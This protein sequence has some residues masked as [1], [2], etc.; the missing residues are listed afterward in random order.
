M[1]ATVLAS[2]SR[3]SS[4]S[5]SKALAAAVS[6]GQRRALARAVTLVESS[7]PDHQEAAG[8]LLQQLMPLTGKAFRIGISGAPGVGKSSFIEALGLHLIAAGYKI[9]VLS[10]DPSSAISGGSILGDK[11][12]M[13]QLSRQASAFIRPSPAGRTLGGIA[14]H[15]REAM[16]LCEA[17]GYDI[18]LIETVGVGQSEIS[19]AGMTDMF[20]LL[21]QP[22][23]GDEIQGIKRGIMELADLVLINKADGESAAAAQRSAADYRNAVRLMQPRSPDWKVPV[24][25]CSA[26][27]LLG[28]EQAW[29]IMQRYRKILTDTGEITKR[30][31]QQARNWLWDEITGSLLAALKA[32]A[33]SGQLLSELENA[34]AAGV[35]PASLAARR[36][37]DNF[38]GAESE[39]PGL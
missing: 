1:S 28:I 27:T 19:A 8:E 7:R 18:V 22:G 26:M 15:T 36:L 33:A 35:L 17:A 24:E 12:R 21:L 30:R 3:S 11:T 39:R 20:V 4:L 16:L 6:T 13:E 23:A 2:T 14:R 10:I 31:R 25:L 9:A 38:L 29:E 37:L 32:D 5:N 34:V